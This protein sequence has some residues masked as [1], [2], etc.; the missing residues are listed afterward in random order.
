MGDNCFQYKFN[1]TNLE[2]SDCERILGVHID[3][4]IT[5][6]NHVYI[7]IKKAS[8]VCNCILSNVYNA[9]NFRLIQLFKTYARLFLDCASVIYSPHFMYLIDAIESVQ[10]NFTKRLY[11]VKNMS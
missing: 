5:F 9:D 4:K 8:N 11:G 1:D 6:A 7:C 10:C 2:I 3:N